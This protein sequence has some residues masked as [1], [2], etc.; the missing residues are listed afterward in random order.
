MVRVV[1]IEPTLLAEHDFELGNWRYRIPIR[2]TTK[3]AISLSAL[4][5]QPS[6]PNPFPA[7]TARKPAAGWLLVGCVN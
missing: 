4:A 3:C 7:G 5:F 6:R 2:S 1:G